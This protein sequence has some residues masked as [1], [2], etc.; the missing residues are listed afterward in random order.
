MASNG[1]TIPAPDWSKRVEVGDGSLTPSWVAAG[2]AG[3][4]FLFG[5][6]GLTILAVAIAAYVAWDVIVGAVQVVKRAAAAIG[7]TLDDSQSL[8]VLGLVAYGI[9]EARK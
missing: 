8:F 7:L 5:L 3:V 4:A 2:A 1:S 6:P 9:W